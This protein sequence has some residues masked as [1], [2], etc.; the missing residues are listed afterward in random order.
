MHC[1]DTYGPYEFSTAESAEEP[2]RKRSQVNAI[3]GLL[4][5]SSTC[6]VMPWC[7]EHCADSRMPV[8]VGV[9]IFPGSCLCVYATGGVATDIH[10]RFSCPLC[11]YWV[12]STARVMVV[13]ASTRSEPFLDYRRFEAPDLHPYVTSETL[14]ELGLVEYK[15]DTFS[16]DYDDFVDEKRPARKATG[17]LPVVYPMDRHATHSIRQLQ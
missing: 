9:L 13:H 17:R 12:G 16:S 14:Q 8:F 11:Q 2:S 5:G 10:M 6:G 3:G 1:G 7:A 4:A 15:V